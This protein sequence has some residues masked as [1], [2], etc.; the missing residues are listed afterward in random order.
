[1]KTQLKKSN[2]SIHNYV[3]G[4]YGIG[5]KD[6]PT[7]T[8]IIFGGD[9]ANPDNYDLENMGTIF[10]NWDGKVNE[11]GYISTEIEP[12]PPTNKPFKSIKP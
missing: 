10:E 1:M 9:S 12:T 6:A 3:G 4:Y 7:G 2:Y 8:G 11:E 5:I